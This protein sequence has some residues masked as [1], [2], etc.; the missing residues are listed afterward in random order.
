MEELCVSLE[1]CRILR[2]WKLSMQLDSNI[3]KVNGSPPKME[4][5]KALSW[6]KMIPNQL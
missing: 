1:L 6:K 2:G 4:Q 3:Y 5:Q